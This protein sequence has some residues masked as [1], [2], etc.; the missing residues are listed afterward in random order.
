MTTA[1]SD[2]R[3]KRQPLRKVATGIDGL[4]EIL[5]GGV[6]RGRST[7]VQGGAGSG[8]SLMGLELLYRNALKGEPGIL[9]TFEERAGSIRQNA[10]TLGW[11][12]AA[13]EQDG[14]FFLLEARLDPTT[15][16]AGDFNL[17][18]LVKMIEAKARA[19]SARLIVLDALDALLQLLDNPQRERSALHLL[20]EQ[21]LEQGMTTLL[22]VKRSAGTGAPSNYEFLDYMTDCIIRLDQRTRD[23]ISTRRLQVVKYRGSD[24]GK[25]EY[26]FAITGSGIKV[27]STSIGEFD[28]SPPGVRLTSGHSGLDELLG[29]GLL[30]GTCFLV[31]G[32]SGTGK[33]TLTS[34]FS[35][36]AHQR[37]D[38]VLNIGFEESPDSL[39]AAMLS[40]GS[41]CGRP[42]RP[43]TCVSSPCT[44][45]PRGPKSI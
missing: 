3:D 26:P 15:V 5:Q 18:G 36:A 43:E 44:P 9:A 21:L 28:H 10:M 6:A 25:N 4:D 34:V 42:L 12:L 2:T 14:R 45:N 13:L 37:G 17:S 39:V 11:D 32:P 41:I 16:K 30:K 7:L 27:I 33:T 29:G 40:P 8:K 31:A 24:Y 23:Q 1:T 35:T 19:M 38:R 22:T 20:H